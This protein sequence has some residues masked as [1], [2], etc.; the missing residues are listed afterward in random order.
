MR[1]AGPRENAGLERLADGAMKIDSTERRG[2]LPVNPAW[3]SGHTSNLWSGTAGAS[4]RTPDSSLGCAGRWPWV[5]AIKPCTVAAI[6]QTSKNTTR[7][8]ANGSWIIR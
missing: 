3:H 4:S 6:R 5:W 2:T 7:P 1:G 8:A